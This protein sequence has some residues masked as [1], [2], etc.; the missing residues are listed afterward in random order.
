[1]STGSPRQLWLLPVLLITVIATALGALVA[2]SV[3]DDPQ[4][5][6]PAAVEPSPS[7]VPPS[8]QPGPTEVRGTADATTHPLY[9]TLRPL[10]QQY[11]DAINE[12]DYAR[13]AETVTKE[14]LDKQDEETWQ[15]DYRTTSDGSIVMYR[16]ETNGDGTASVLLQFTSTQDPNDAPPELAAPCIHWNV[17]W[18][19]AK[20]RDT[21][22]LSAGSTSASPQHE[23]CE[24]L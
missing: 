5:Q 21:W 2:R 19:F 8:E 7:S 22:K 18:A 15:N 14:R 10:L 1:V 17:V 11:F 13:W 16:I 4:P 23:P 20:E 12:K 9:N 24:G 3:Y 6:T